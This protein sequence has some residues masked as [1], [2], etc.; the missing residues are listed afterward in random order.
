MN[1]FSR[2][3]GA[4]LL[5][6][7][8]AQPVFASQASDVA[9]ITR[10]VEVE[11]EGA[12]AHDI[13]KVMSVY[14]HSA[15]L[16][17]YDGAPGD[18]VGW[19]A[20]RGAYMKY[21]TSFPTKPTATHTDLHVDVSGDLGYARSVQTWKLVKPDGSIF[22]TVQRVTEVYKRINGRWLCVHEHAS[23]PVDYFKDTET[24]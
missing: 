22:T 8:L 10:L 16:V 24:K 20:V 5:C 18:Y 9:A 19:D 14:A 6:C 15:E 13:D 12:A 23:M 17:L 3:I 11:M 1:R 7:A 21:F 2:T 4:A